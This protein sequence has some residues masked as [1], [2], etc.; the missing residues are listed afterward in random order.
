ML[1]AVSW[2][3]A[4]LFVALRYVYLPFPSVPKPALLTNASLE[5]SFRDLQDAHHAAYLKPQLS[6]F[7]EISIFSQISDD[8]IVLQTSNLKMHFR[9]AEHIFT[10]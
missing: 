2:A 6:S 3:I 4:E 10:Y 7:S 8:T 1:S 5:S 9:E